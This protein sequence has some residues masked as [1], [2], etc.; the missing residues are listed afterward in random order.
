M[1]QTS[2]ARAAAS[3]V[4]ALLMAA[5]APA[6]AQTPTEA[7]AEVAP[8]APAEA[9]AET[10]AMPPETLEPIAVPDPTPAAPATPAAAAAAE[11]QG[12]EN[13]V[14]LITPEAG[15]G[16]LTEDAST[17]Q[18]DQTVSAGLS[19][20]WARGDMKV[21]LAGAWQQHERTYL[22]E[23]SDLDGGVPM[24]RVEEMSAHGE[25]S[26][27]YD[28]ATLAGVDWRDTAF[29]IYGG[30][31]GRQLIND[32][33]PSLLAGVMVGAEA[34]LAVGQGLRFDAGVDYTHHI[35]RF[36]LDE[37]LDETHSRHGKQ[38]GWM[39]WRGTFSLAHDDLASLGLGYR[40]G[41]LALEHTNLYDHGAEVALTIALPL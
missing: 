23:G 14:L 22:A 25:A 6:A 38:L 31:L 3:A 1:R 19:I 29:G 30:L 35:G 26:F 32:V 15:F 21:E 16:W 4:A 10:P 36:F 12:G 17:G 33:Y 40:G 7:P 9:T 20:A 13:G 18:A 28:F 8:A 11:A 37:A 39:R 41:W 34:G 5:A 2:P 27:H 24:V